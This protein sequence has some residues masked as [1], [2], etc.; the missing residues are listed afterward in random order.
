MDA[1]TITLCIT[2]PAYRAA[3][4]GVF[5]RCGIQVKIGY[6]QAIGRAEAK[7]L[8]NMFRKF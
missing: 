7:G 2:H 6:K 8:H 1:L 3:S 5:L 4:G